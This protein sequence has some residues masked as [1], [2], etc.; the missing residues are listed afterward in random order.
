[1][2][3]EKIKSN[4][5]EESSESLDFIRKIVTED[6]KSNKHG[7][8]VHTRFPPEPNG[9]MHIGHA[10]AIYLNFSVA[11]EF[12]G[13]FNLRYDDT[14]PEKESMEYVKSIQEDVQW[15]GCDWEDRL[16][17]ASDYFEKLYGFAIALIKTGYAYVCDLSAE[18]IKEQ[19][20]TLTE[21][22][23]NSPYRDRSVEENLKQ[24]EGMR[25][26]LY[27]DGSKVLR[28]KIDMNSPNVLMRDPVMYRIKR[29]PHYR[30]GTDW[31]I[32]PS[33]DWTHGQSDAIEGITHSLCSLEFVPHRELYDWFV[34]RLIEV[35]MLTHQPRQYEFSRLNLTY[36]VTSKR[37]LLQLVDE[38]HV[39]G[40]DDP[41]M[42]TLSGMR[43]R[44]YPAAAIRNFLDRVG[45]SK[46]ENYIDMGLLETC[47]R[48]ELDK[49]SKRVM[50]VLN[51]LKIV[52]TNFPE[53]HVEEVEA[54]NHP[55][56]P[57]KGKRLLP[58]SKELYIERQDFMEV[59]VKKFYRLAPGREVRLRYGY[60]IKCEDV[61]KDETTNEIVEVHCTYDPNTKGGFSPDGRKV[62]A[63]LHWISAKHAVPAKAQLYDRLFLVENPLEYEDF[64]SQINPESL[65][66]LDCFVEDSL[67]NV[68]GGET[69]QFERLGYF[70]V[71]PIK[72]TSKTPVFNRT[73]TLRDT[74][75]KIRRKQS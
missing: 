30:T 25:N 58:F 5:K 31:I 67:K 12:N 71:D 45:I 63:T 46:R 44:G 7:G 11:Q 6:V 42:P 4:N 66:V 14:D 39:E 15:L 75:A 41:R 16:Y 64:K 70:S 22:G 43:R 59:P 33:Y 74:W 23:T 13:L 61:I 68:K 38:K 19:R 51:P 35:E 27:E 1:M 20:G 2:N 60:Y 8:K 65:K 57:S 34:D 28:A 10:K 48:E 24:F 69:Y 73:A 72:S 37:R 52:I 40:W 29:V 17:F 21:V 54:Q 36:T 47:V 26:G 18:E 53:D 55:K 50:G 3:P 49:T 32:F 62:K 9:Y 56:D